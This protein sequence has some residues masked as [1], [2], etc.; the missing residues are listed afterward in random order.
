MMLLPELGMHLLA[1]VLMPP[2]TG[3]SM[4][5]KACTY[6]GYVG[7]GLEGLMGMLIYGWLEE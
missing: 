5:A 3:L 1:I 7:K 2:L 4:T 6:T